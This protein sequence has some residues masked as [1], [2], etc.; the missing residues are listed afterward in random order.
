MVHVIEDFI[1][2]SWNQGDNY[3]LESCAAIWDGN[4]LKIQYKRSKNRQ[5]VVG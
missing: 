2:M 1:G 5:F 3:R 4:D